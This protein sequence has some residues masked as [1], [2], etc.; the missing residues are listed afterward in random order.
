MVEISEELLKE[1]ERKYPKGTEFISLNGNKSISSGLNVW[2]SG[3]SI[4]IDNTN[5]WAR[6]IY[7]SKQGWAT[8]TSLP[9]QKKTYKIW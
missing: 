7:N 6:E 3:D 1:A 9:K 4:F 5:S 2:N 8:I